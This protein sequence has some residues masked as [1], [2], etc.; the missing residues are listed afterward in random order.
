M[1]CGRKARGH[2]ALRPVLSERVKTV[3][4]DDGRNSKYVFEGGNRIE[5][6]TLSRY[7]KPG[8]GV[9]DKESVSGYTMTRSG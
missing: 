5:P 8:P 9:C 2:G 3:V 4:A 7:R 6:V 1:R